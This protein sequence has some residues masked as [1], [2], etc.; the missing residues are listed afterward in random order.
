MTVESY[1]TMRFCKY[2]RSNNMV[3]HG[4]RRNKPRVVQRFMCLNLCH[5]TSR[6]ST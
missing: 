5:A 1:D 2:C 6:L 3:R 4:T